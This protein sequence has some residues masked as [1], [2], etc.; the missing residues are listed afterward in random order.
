MSEAKKI[1]DLM[2][3]WQLCRLYPVYDEYG[4]VDVAAAVPATHGLYVFWDQQ[5]QPLYIGKS[6]AIRFR[7][8]Q[9][10]KTEESLANGLVGLATCS[11]P[12]YLLDTIEATLIQQ[13]KP[14][15]NS[16]IS[17]AS[18]C[19]DETLAMT[20]E[21]LELIPDSTKLPWG[22]TRHEGG[23]CLKESPAP[24]KE[25]MKRRIRR[26]AMQPLNKLRKYGIDPVTAK[27][28][29]EQRAL[30]AQKVA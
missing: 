6:D 2:Y 12:I 11:P 15:L 8:S 5:L 29:F 4:P 13:L 18:L 30:I 25:E 7:I 3:R 9:H 23:G 22:D 10:H 14:R 21:Q 19:T 24:A 1:L 20:L 17:R 16:C 26:L 28:A 27:V